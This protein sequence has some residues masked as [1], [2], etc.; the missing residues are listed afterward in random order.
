[1]VYIYI[2]KQRKHTK[3]N[4]HF[5]TKHDKIVCANTAKIIFDQ[6]LPPNML[7]NVCQN[8]T[9]RLCTGYKLEN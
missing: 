9:Y 8:S 3:I 6:F 4:K 1:M 7:E 2:K 5:H